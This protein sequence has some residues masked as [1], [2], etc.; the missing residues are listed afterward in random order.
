ML[1]KILSV[2]KQQLWGSDLCDVTKAANSLTDLPYKIEERKKSIFSGI[3][4]FLQ[5][6][7]LC[8]CSA[9]IQEKMLKNRSKAVGAIWDL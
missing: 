5:R 1:A 4:S 9:E 8:L 3:S 6:I 7:F 2:L